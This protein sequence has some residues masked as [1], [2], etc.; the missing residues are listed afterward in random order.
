MPYEW[1]MMHS[2]GWLTG[3]IRTTLTMEERSIWAD[4]L[5]MANESRVR[6]IICRAEGIP[7]TREYLAS[8]LGVPIEVL[9][10]TIT[11]C[12]GDKNATD[13]LHRIELD[14]YGSI[15]I[16][17]WAKYQAVPDGKGKVKKQNIPLS[18]EDRESSQKAAA[19]RLGYLQPGAA[20]RGIQHREI[21][22]EVKKHNKEVG[23]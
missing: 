7:Y 10:S 14:A 8:Y 12:L 4:L 5:A 15:V 9:N 1:Y 20:G 23:T 11:K 6:G 3:T 2:K 22:E 16:T 19:A 17:N 13:N 21:E 18:P